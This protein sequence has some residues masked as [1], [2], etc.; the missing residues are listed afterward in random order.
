MRI[1]IRLFAVLREKAGFDEIPLD[2][3]E[4]ST[5]AEVAQILMK[6][7]PALRPMADIALFAVNTEYVD[8]NYFLTENDELALIPPV[9]GGMQRAHITPDI[10]DTKAITQSVHKPEYGAVTTFE[11]VVRQQNLGRTVAYLVYDAYIPMA[12]AEMERIA[13]E[14]EEKW[15]SM[16]VSMSHRTGRLEIGEVSIVV[17]VASGHRK[18]SFEACR[19]IVDQIKTRVPIWKKEIWEDGEEWIGTSGSSAE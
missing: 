19:Y 14:A 11:G 2:V 6:K 15:G 17:A 1:K 8:A 4:G 12:E 18:E 3:E 9:S 16:G 7:Y 13:I 5:A 10:L